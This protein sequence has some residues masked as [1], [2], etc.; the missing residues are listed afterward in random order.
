MMDAP[1]PLALP[2]PTIGGSFQHAWGVLKRC[3]P[4]LL[5]IVVLWLV[6][7]FAGAVVQAAWERNESASAVGQLI[8]LAYSLFF[9]GPVE[10]GALYAF[11]KAVRGGRP[12]I[13][14]L[15][16]AFRHNYVSAVVA[17]TLA[18]L[19]IVFGLFLFVLPGLYL[20]MRFSF[21][22]FLVMDEGLGPLEALGESWRRTSGRFWTLLG[23]AALGLFVV[24]VGVIL[25]V[26]GSIVGI[27]LAGLAFATLYAAAS[28]ERA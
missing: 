8:G 21:V 1:V 6:V 20:A 11:L 23:A 18:S 22:G 5:A 12:E 9:V 19:L 14:D 27:A 16:A 24:W 7:V 3:W 26:V 13:D 25:L 17:P 15:F 2:P 28:R 4:K 10:I